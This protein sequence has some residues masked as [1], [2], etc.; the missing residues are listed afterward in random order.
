MVV[1]IA[2]TRAEAG[3]AALNTVSSTVPQAQLLRGE[4][5]SHGKAGICRRSPGRGQGDDSMTRA[6]WCHG[7]S[8]VW[9]P[10][11]AD[12]YEILERCGRNH[13]LLERVEPVPF[14][15]GAR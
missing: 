12:N 6:C 1:E 8:A 7:R 11:P 2:L 3:N 5:A 9:L 15:S 4:Q 13:R 14:L 10:G